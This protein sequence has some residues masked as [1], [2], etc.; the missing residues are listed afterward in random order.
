MGDDDDVV[1][2]AALFPFCLFLTTFSRAV[3]H[4]LLH[5]APARFKKRVVVGDREKPL[6]HRNFLE[7]K[8]K[9]L[10]LARLFG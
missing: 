9:R 1:R 3:A 5:K 10:H 7:V 2:S 4:G 6:L 8:Q